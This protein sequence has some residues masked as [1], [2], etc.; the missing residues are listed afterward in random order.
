MHFRYLTVLM[1]GLS[2]IMG[3]VAAA[4]DSAWTPPG[5]AV[6]TDFANDLRL[7][8]QSGRLRSIDALMGTRG[9]TV[10][11]VRS[12][13]WCP[14]C[15]RQLAELNPYAAELQSLG[16]PL[17]AVSVDEVPLIK[18]FHEQAGI[19][20]TMLADPTG[21]VIEELGIRDR[22]YPTGDHAFGVPHPGIF[23]V[24][25]DRMILAKFFEQGY[26]ARPDPNAVLLSV[27]TH[28]KVD[29]GSSTDE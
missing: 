16:F 28:A 7:S 26:K 10:A 11:F 14:Y 19:R 6:G 27:R 13:D 8:D 25:R 23:I 22:Q 12:A 4:S 18:A 24:A 2:L 15:K 29:T 20:F 21:R 17:V 1:G 3:M 9:L 5:P